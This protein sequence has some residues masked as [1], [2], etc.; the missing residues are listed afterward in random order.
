[1]CVTHSATHGRTANARRTKMSTH[2]QMQSYIIGPNMHF[3]H[4]VAY[5]IPLIVAAISHFTRSASVTRAASNQR[6][7]NPSLYG[8][9]T[10]L[11]WF[12]ALEAL[13]PHSTARGL[14]DPALGYGVR[15][16]SREPFS[17]EVHSTG[18][19]RVR[20]SL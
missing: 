14:P 7:L 2:I 5:Y 12:M 16:F 8:V 3:K 18:E 17:R 1:M 10:S 15:H 11:S 19:S 9:R 20:F 6:T 13:G 4:H